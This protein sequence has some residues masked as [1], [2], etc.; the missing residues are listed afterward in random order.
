MLVAPSLVGAVRRMGDY[1]GQGLPGETSSAAPHVDDIRRGEQARRLEGMQHLKLAIASSQAMVIINTAIVEY[2]TRRLCNAADVAVD[3]TLWP[4]STRMYF[5]RIRSKKEISEGD[6]RD[7]K[8][9]LRDAE[10]RLDR[11]KQDLRDA[12]NRLREV[13]E[14]P[15]LGATA[16]FSNAIR[17]ATVVL[18]SPTVQTATIDNGFQWLV[19]EQP[20]LYERVR[21]VDMLWTKVQQLVNF[22][23]LVVCGNPGIGKS[24]GMINAMLRRL[25][26]MTRGP[27]E[28]VVVVTL[29]RTHI[30]DYNGR[31][32]AMTMSQVATAGL[33][34][35]KC[36][37]LLHD[38]KAGFR[39][40]HG[41][42]GHVSK[43]LRLVLFTS[44][45]EGNY[46][47]A[48]QH[49][50]NET[51]FYVPTWSFEDLKVMI[52][53]VTQDAFDAVGG[54]P[55]HINSVTGAAQ[56][57]RIEEQDKA[58]ANFDFESLNVSEK[59]TA[60]SKILCIVPT[61]TFDRIS[62]ME[63]VSKRAAKEFARKANVSKLAAV[64]SVL[65]ELLSNNSMRCGFAG[66]AFE[67]FFLRYTMGGM[68]SGKKALVCQ[69]L[70]PASTGQAFLLRHYPTREVADLSQLLPTATPT[71]YVPSAS[72]FACFDAFVVE[73]ADVTA[74][75]VT[76]AES[77]PL[78]QFGM[79]KIK[80]LLDTAKLSL[81]R[82]V[83]VTDAGCKLQSDQT[84][85]KAAT[86]SQI[87]DLVKSFAKDGVAVTPQEARALVEKNASA[88]LD[89]AAQY[90]LILPIKVGAVVHST[91]GTQA[92]ELLL[93]EETID[94]VR[95]VV[96]KS[97]LFPATATVESATEDRPSDGAL[98]FKVA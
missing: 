71:L 69:D 87:N 64:Q 12:E 88:L 62:H 63:F 47:E 82:I 2:V 90:R 95:Q 89:D 78:K 58:L 4:D 56:P 94:D 28:Y 45:Q 44:P 83:W 10:T 76:L 41:V 52:P 19:E 13:K 54:I 30:F 33:S 11:A 36:V 77:H 6:L 46:H 97:K 1:G 25:L 7:A 40:N 35:A 75:Q 80:Q 48:V 43:V 50:R 66:Y 91:V 51:C 73:G 26:A 37:W 39:Y 86:D 3:T 32:L 72:N 21:V 34:K 57:A 18:A 38:I 16:D 98:H 84:L 74:F 53:S 5:E 31:H 9:D 61:V 60:S 22:S 79:C 17:D 55:R 23:S 8:Q 49:V 81:K 24:V 29:E 14:D 68:L 96:A 59:V 65:L 67:G 92:T 15:W 42:W 20:L 93:G 85:G 70:D 27:G